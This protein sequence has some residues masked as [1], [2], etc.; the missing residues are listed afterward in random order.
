V[1]AADYRT[2][3]R[4]V[5]GLDDRA[6]TRAGRPRLL[7]RAKLADAVVASCSIPGWYPPMV[8]DGIPYIDGGA[9]SNASLDVLRYA[10]VDE[11]F[12]FAP[13]AS[14]VADHPRSVAARLERRVRAA[15]T[16]RIVADA[17][18]LRARGVKV[19][20]VTPGPA[21][22]ETMGVNLMNPARRMEV[23]ETARETAGEQIS[24]QLSA[25]HGWGGRRLGSVARG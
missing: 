2:G 11:I 23:L 10:D 24:R 18:V 20:V 6:P 12:V 19:C 13:M 8:I 4:V 15:I 16:R 17:G 5:F 1:V 22:L 7:R 9:V 14:T 25:M 3:R 21:D